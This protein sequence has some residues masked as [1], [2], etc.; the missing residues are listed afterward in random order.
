MVFE[1][2]DRGSEQRLVLAVRVAL[3]HAVPEKQL[4]LLEIILLAEQPK[5][6]TVLATLFVNLQQVQG[7]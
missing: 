3:A 5:E 1:A 4:P 2:E 7:L 6:P